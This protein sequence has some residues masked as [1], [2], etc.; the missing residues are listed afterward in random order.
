MQASTS[1][2]GLSGTPYFSLPSSYTGSLL[3]SYGLSLRFTTSYRG[4]GPP[5]S[6]PLVVLQG[7]GGAPLSYSPSTPLLPGVRN[8]VEVRLWPADWRDGEGGQ[9]GRRLILLLLLL[10]LLNFLLLPLLF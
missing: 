5:L 9:V 10:L 2:L 7:G 3:R 6:A 8:R 1:S 4:S